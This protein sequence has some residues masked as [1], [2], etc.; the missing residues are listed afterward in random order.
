MVAWSVSKLVDTSAVSVTMS[1]LSGNDFSVVGGIVV[2]G[3]L[4]RTRQGTDLGCLIEF[5]LVLG[6]E[7]GRVDAHDRHCEDCQQDNFTHVTLI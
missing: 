1:I 3:A 4:C 6:W 7:N 5:H 2:D